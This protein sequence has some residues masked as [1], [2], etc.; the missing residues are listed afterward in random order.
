MV[1]KKL[2]VE[3]EGVEV[4]EEEGGG[5]GGEEGVMIVEGASAVVPA[6]RGSGGESDRAEMVA[7]P[8]ISQIEVESSEEVVGVEGKGRE[9]RKG[10][11]SQA[12]SDSDG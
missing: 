2:E 8:D 6:G 3:V 5:R 12:N 4:V 11:S 10:S 1:V 7:D 9:G